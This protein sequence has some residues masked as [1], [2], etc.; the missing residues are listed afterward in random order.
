MG[1]GIDQ[2][3]TQ[4]ETFLGDELLLPET[5]DPTV[6]EVRG[7]WSLVGDTSGEVSYVILVP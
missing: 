5:D 3:P 1:K 7:G 4:A 2:E 6:Y